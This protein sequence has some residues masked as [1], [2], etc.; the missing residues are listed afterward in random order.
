MHELTRTYLDAN[1]FQLIG[2]VPVITGVS[3]GGAIL[4]KQELTPTIVLLSIVGALVTLG[5]YRW[6]RRN[7][8]I[9]K[10][11]QERVDEIERNQFD[12]DAAET[13]FAIRLNPPGKAPA[14]RNPKYNDLDKFLW[15]KEFTQRDAEKIIYWTALGAWIALPFA[16]A[17]SH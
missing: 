10:W 15:W 14:F 9:C 8:K 16:V 2:L 3:I 6:E 12:L 5:L 1:S 11:M 13:Q 7:V 4:T 17:L